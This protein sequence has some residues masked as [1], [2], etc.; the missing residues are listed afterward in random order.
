MDK[1][2]LG[3]TSLACSLQ[4]IPCA[5]EIHGA[6]IRS[7]TKEN[8]YEIIS[9]TLGWDQ[10]LHEQEP[11][12]PERHTMVQREGEIIGFFC[13]REAIDHLYL[14]TIQLLPACRNQ[15]YGT[16]LLEHIEQIAKSKA[17]PK[18]CLSVFQ[19]NPA[20]FLY[21]RLGYRPLEVNAS[22]KLIL[23]EKQLFIS[24]RKATPQEQQQYEEE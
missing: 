20:Q 1:S 13:I 2:G 8:F 4:L 6:F 9:R 7:L 21:Q 12:F 14:H 19:E 23:M 24:A 18:I 17:L 10:S 11:R 15:G 22:R 5:P 3:T 16:L